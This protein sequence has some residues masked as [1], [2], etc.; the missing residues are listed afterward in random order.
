MFSSVPQ[1]QMIN[2]TRET[3]GAIQSGVMGSNQE[4][5]CITE[6]CQEI[7]AKETHINIVK[8]WS[9]E[10][11]ILRNAWN[12]YDCVCMCIS[13]GGIFI[14]MVA[15]LDIIYLF[16]FYTHNSLCNKVNNDNLR[17]NRAKFYSYKL[18][19]IIPIYV[20]YFLDS[21]EWHILTKTLL[22]ETK[23]LRNFW[24]GSLRGM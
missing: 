21:C 4:R 5:A 11:R 2:V 3:R 14:E 23:L 10:A 19:L 1:P 24:K 13:S 16:S 12:T 9:R 6:E 8:Q 18:V 22:L 20:L 17:L 15:E 7:W